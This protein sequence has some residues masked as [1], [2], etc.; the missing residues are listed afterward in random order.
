MIHKYV[1]PADSIFHQ[2]P[3]PSSFMFIPYTN[4]T[5]YFRGV[6]LYQDRIKARE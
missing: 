5:W 2:L 1:E 3:N 6:D 4:Y